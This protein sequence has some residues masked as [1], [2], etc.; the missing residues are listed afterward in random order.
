MVR[1]R[2]K[3]TAHPPKPP[4]YNT[5][6][7][8]PVPTPPNEELAQTYTNV[9][10]PTSDTESVVELHDDGSILDYLTITAMSAEPQRVFSAAKITL[11][12]RRCRMEDDAIEAL[13]CLKSW[14]RDGLI[15]ASREDIKAIEDMLNALCEEDLG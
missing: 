8:E 9:R 13:E 6:S 11:S 7:D 15:A 14:Q 4:S 10:T 2:G 5:T 12:D 3:Q 1:P